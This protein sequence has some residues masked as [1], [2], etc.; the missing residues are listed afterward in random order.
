MSLSGQIHVLQVG[1]FYP[2]HMGGIETHLQ[3]LCAELKDFVALRVVVANDGR[4]QTESVVDGVRVCRLATL[5]NI[6]S[7][8]MCRRMAHEIRN[9]RADIVHIHLPNPM[10]L[11]SYLASGQK[12]SLVLTWHS[13]VLR[14]K[15][16]RKALLPLEIQALR[17]CAACIVTSE[18]YRDSSPILE[19]YKHLC[20][21][22]PYGI[23][24]HRFQVLDKQEVA[25]LHDQYSGRII[26]GVGRLVYYKGFEYLIRAMKHIQGHLLLVGD[27]PL[28][29]DL[30]NEARRLGL[31][32]RIF[33]LGEIQNEQ[34]APYLHAANVFVLPSVAR[35]EAF[36]IVQLEA[37]AC[38]TPVVNTSIESGV[39]FVSLDG[40]TGLTVAP[41]DSLALA[42]A[43][44]RLLTDADLRKRYGQAAARRVQ[45]KFTAQRMAKDILNL[46]REILLEHSQQFS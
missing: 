46:Y 2:P 9:T 44:N 6:N 14:Q 38:E 18:S 37:M 31:M 15:V 4:R 5:F 35:T 16:L 30:E 13:D 23:Q 22:V 29:D 36:G 17:R 42:N 26:L 3:V 28:R 45:Q 43:I 19:K 8:P 40:E 32:N 7:T 11:V 24:L 34:L 33:F 1:K 41:C 21:I 25:R 27:G 39:P 10:A 20:R 12:Q